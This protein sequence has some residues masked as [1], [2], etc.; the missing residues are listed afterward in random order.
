M[1]QPRPV[2]LRD[3]T[4]ERLEALSPK[5]RRAARFVVE[6]PGDIATRSQRY[7]ADVAK[8]PPPTFTRLAHAVGLDSYDM[9]RDLCRED[10]L[11]SRTVLADRAQALV[12]APTEGH[13]DL[14]SRH[15]GATM[16]NLQALL[17]RIDATQMAQVATCLAQA[18]RVVLVGEMSARGLVDYASYVA[19]MS[20]TGWKVLGRAGESLSAELA[21]LGPGDACIVSSISPYS[22]R[23]IDTARHVA[24][25]GVPV[26]AITDNALSPLASL[27]DHYFLVGTES[28][29]FFPSHV[30]SMVFFET[31]VDMVIRERGAQAQHHIAAVERQN[32]KLK[33][34]WQDGPAGKEGV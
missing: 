31:L 2:R 34:Y 16:R 24:D 21:V 10:L 29:Q 11:A 23:A 30:P 13:A 26:I 6:N 1:A 5:L 20:L 19:N 12:E 15:A 22:T 18:N 9:L 33:E 8:L 14:L 28:P 3:L 7:V 17:D 4:P 32:H 27:A 25:C